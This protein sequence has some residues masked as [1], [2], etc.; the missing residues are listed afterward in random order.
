MHI[1]C[2]GERS[3]LR[4]LKWTLAAGDT[5]SRGYQT[6]M[7]PH[8]GGPGPTDKCQNLLL[9]VGR[10]VGMQALSASIRPT[11]S[12]PSMPSCPAEVDGQTVHTNPSTNEG[13]RPGLG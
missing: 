4:E 9:R 3:T 11:K 8:P 12:T 5:E 13:T 1:S 6:D 2:E 7:E 10:G